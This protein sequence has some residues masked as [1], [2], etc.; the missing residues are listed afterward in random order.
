M[1]H[2]LNETQKLYL[3]KAK[4]ASKNEDSANIKGRQGIFPCRLEIVLD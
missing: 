2:S 3:I 4:K 1:L